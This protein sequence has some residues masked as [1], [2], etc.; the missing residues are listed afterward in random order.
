MKRSALFLAAAVASFHAVAFEI[1]FGISGCDPT[2]QQTLGTS[3]PWFDIV[4]YCA[5]DQD[6]PTA[7]RGVGGM[8]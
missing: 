8:P 6:I 4:G 5:K 1:S 2:L 3:S 7:T